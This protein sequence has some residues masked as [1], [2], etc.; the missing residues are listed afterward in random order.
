MEEW[1]MSLD[2]WLEASTPPMDPRGGSGIFIRR[3]GETV[4]ISREE[5]DAHF[6]GQE[7]VTLTAEYGVDCTVYE[8][9]I[10]HNLGKMADAAGVY[11]AM[12]WPEEIGIATAKQLI[13]PLTIG[14][15]ALRADP[16][17]FKAFNPS[18]GWGNYDG[19]VGFVESYL[20]AAKRYPEATVRISR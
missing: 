9:N 3:N 18:N 7:P 1:E 11:K 13:D 15:E 6:P 12:W 2:V 17:K 4:E 16:E 10:T 14:L 19:L 5:W 8:R 20:D